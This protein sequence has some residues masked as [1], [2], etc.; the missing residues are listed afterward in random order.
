MPN[1]DTYLRHTTT[2][3][4]VLALTLAG[5]IA[6][7][8][9]LVLLLDS[10]QQQAKPGEF[11]PSNIIKPTIYYVAHAIQIVLLLAAALVSLMCDGL[12]G[13]E[14][15]YFWRFG[16]FI[17]AVFLMTAKGYSAAD[18]TSTRLVDSMGP[19][20]YLVSLL[21]FVGARQ[22]YWS[23][24][25][26]AMVIEA[27]FLSVMALTA[28][29]SLHSF[30]R[31]RVIASLGGTLDALYWPAAWIALRRYTRDSFARHLRFLPILLYGFVSFFTETRLNVVMLL[32]CL[33]VYSYVEYKRLTPQIA[34]W[35]V[36]LGVVVWTGTLA[37]IVLRD[38]SALR[39]V[40]FVADSFYQ[41]IDE[42]T[43]SGQIKSFFDDVEPSELVLGR[44]ALATWNWGRTEWSGGT[45][46]GY[47]TILFYGGIPLLLT[48]IVTH[49]RPAFR[50]VRTSP[51]GRQLA[52]A[53]IV[54]LWTIR[55]F[56]SSYPNLT[57][58]YYPVALCVGACISRNVL[59][60]SLRSIDR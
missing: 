19:F 55:M 33:G 57:L 47:L 40:E 45:D 43:R 5:L 7:L 2:D 58:S 17:G 15:G 32:A 42:D 29:S 8:A 12:R 9:T 39:T 6:A 1:C 49:I 28:L 35:V 60:E 16:L 20:P 24:I 56:S 54:V 36:G 21:V 11:I 52:A 50:V 3:R 27:V 10:I 44:G 13:I 25:D 30:T 37:A 53:G 41:R 46:I 51:D 22:K 34:T 14:R 38:T 18:L 23:V 48:Y 4:V 31:D 26:K 59:T